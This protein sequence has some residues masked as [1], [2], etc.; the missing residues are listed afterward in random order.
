M[1]INIGRALEAYTQY[2][3]GQ[4][5]NYGEKPLIEFIEKINKYGTTLRAR[6]EVNFSGIEDITFFVTDITTPN[7]RQNFGHVFFEGKNV[8][9]PINIE[10]DHDVT[11]T[12]LNDGSGVLY[13][14]IV[15]W[16][17][18]QDAGES[19]VNSGY[20]MTIRSLGDGVSQKGMT[21]VLEGVRMRNIS[22]LT[23]VSSD[24]SVSTFT[25]TL[26]VISFKAILGALQ[27]VGGTVGALGSLFK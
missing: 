22:G 21:I 25:L 11:L 17:L 10:Y 16:M 18:N 9:I 2:Q 23:Y 27:E 13:T 15:N 12:I 7:L 1:A 4:A 20:T 8:E 6:Y 5:Q 26:S 14:T 3:T 19:V 24:A